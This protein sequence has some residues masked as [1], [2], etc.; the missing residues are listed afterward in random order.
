MQYSLLLPSEN[1]F[2]AWQSNSSQVQ[3][4]IKLLVCLQPDD[5]TGQ[6]LKDIEPFLILFIWIRYSEPGRS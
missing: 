4:I 1:M 5:P 3:K 6:A 2:L